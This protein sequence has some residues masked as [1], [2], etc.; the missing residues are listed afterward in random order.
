MTTRRSAPEVIEDLEDLDGFGA[1]AFEAARRAGFPSAHALEKWLER[2]DAYPLWLR[3]KHRDP[4]GA[5]ERKR[6]DQN[7]TSID[8]IIALLDRAD[9]SPKKARGRKADRIRDLIKT[10]RAD[11]DSDDK[12]REAER[13][14]RTE[15]ERLEAE[16]AEA[17]AR[18]R[19]GPPPA[20]QSA[21]D[22][23]TIRAWAR[24]NDVACPTKG[25]VPAAV[26]EAYETRQAAS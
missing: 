11:L 2:N 17:K 19:G 13:E 3:L 12:R 9:E 22:A 15:V 7:V 24:E 21:G 25:R 23:A 26:R 14:A 1:G 4:E 5:H 16:L 10:L 18:L 6:K 20:A 8:P